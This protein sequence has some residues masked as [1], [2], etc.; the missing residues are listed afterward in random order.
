[1]ENHEHESSL[2]VIKTHLLFSQSFAL[3]VVAQA[4]LIFKLSFG[5]NVQ[6]GRPFLVEISLHLLSLTLTLTS[7]LKLGD[8]FR[9]MFHSLS[10]Q[11]I[12]LLCLM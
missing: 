6:N 2:N 7:S 8:I 4:T 5:M 3:V 12:G 1:M 10:L 11:I 9:S